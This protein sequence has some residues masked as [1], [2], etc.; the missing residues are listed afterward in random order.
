MMKIRS[1]FVFRSSGFPKTNDVPMNYPRRLFTGL[2]LLLS[3]LGNAQGSKPKQALPVRILIIFD[4]S[5]SMKANYEGVSR[6][7]AA[8]KLMNR[9]V[10]SLQRIPNLELAL[11]IYG[12]EKMYPPGD[13]NDSRLAVPFSRNNI[14]LIKSKV[15]PLKPTGITPIAHSLNLAA[16]DFPSTPSTNIILL[17]TDGIEEC[18]GDPCEAARKLREKGIVF[19]PYIL[20][21]GLSQEQSKAFDCVGTYFSA[22]VS[23]SLMNVV[24]VVITQTM[25]RTTA[26]VNLLDKSG[27]PKETNVDMTFYDHFSGNVRYNY[28]HTLNGLGNPD[29]LTL[30][31]NPTYD[32]VVHTIPP[33]EKDN[34]K[35]QMGIH[36]IIALD[37]GQGKLE[38]RRTNGI[39]N[40]NYKI[41]TLV[42][43]QG[44]PAILNMQEFNAEEKYLVGTYDLEILT[45]P[46]IYLNDVGVDQSQSKVLDIPGAGELRLMT[47]EAGSG[48]IY[49]EEKGDL[50]W[51]CN[52][53]NNQTIQNF[54]LQPGNYRVEFRARSRKE[55]A[56]T[57]EKKFTIA[58]DKSVTVNLY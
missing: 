25:N 3:V 23:N 1:V 52:L 43:K 44:D 21:I 50:R 7:E 8:K 37:A 45:L 54:Y 12:A 29:T 27:N 26:Q 55:S 42:R 19:K 28:I 48:S 18:S 32:L 14:A 58:T 24:N 13:C 53:D 30:D 5:N 40:F 17:I 35:L 36:N 2:L 34:V 57:I 49:L 51:V 56:Y 38:L 31:A 20:G 11:R 39:Y 16:D 6:I 41:K 15:L 22:E 46:R 47:G 33:V 10:D 9:I 4:A